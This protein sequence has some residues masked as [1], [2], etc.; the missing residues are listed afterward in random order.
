MEGAE[1]SSERRGT[2]FLDHVNIFKKASKV[3]R[4]IVRQKERDLARQRE[5]EMEMIRNSSAT[6]TVGDAIGGGT[7]SGGLRSH[8]LFG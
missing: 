3:K 1:G 6:H 7:I 8:A 4:R 2:S 5:L